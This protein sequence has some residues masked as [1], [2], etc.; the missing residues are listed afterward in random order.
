MVK[1]RDGWV[2][3]AVALALLLPVYF[4]VAALG[5]KFGLID[6][7]IG[8][9]LLVFKLGALVVFGVLGFAVIALLL[10]LLVKPRAGWKAAVVAVL[11][12]ALFVGYA[13]SVMAK[14][15]TIPPIHDVSTN[16]QDP[17]LFSSAVLDARRTMGANPIESMTTPLRDLPKYKAM[18]ASP[19]LAP[20]ADKSVGDLGLAANPGVRPLTLATPPAQAF[21]RALA[22]ARQQGWTIVRADKPTGMIEATAST[23][24]FGFK[25]DVAVRVRPA[26]GGAVVDVRSTSRVGLG[27]IGANGK[28][29]AKFLADLKG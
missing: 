22:A 28:R 20:M 4:L 15:K 3:L 19:R 7:K 18:A 5:T 13:A 27:D 11:I 14:S 17:P 16:P 2:R 23:F 9:G 24:W 26:A 8:F 25:D 1:L 10:A 6:W 29:V 21:D 12:P